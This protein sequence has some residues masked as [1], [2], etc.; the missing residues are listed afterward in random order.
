MKF[1][2]IKEILALRCEK[3]PICR[4]ARKKPESLFGKMMSFHGRFCPFWR[5]WQEVYGAK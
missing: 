3:C 1:L 5:A 2:K 4:Y